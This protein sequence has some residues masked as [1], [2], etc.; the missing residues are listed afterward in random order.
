MQ[1]WI[2]A[3]SSGVRVSRC[4]NAADHQVLGEDPDRG[5]EV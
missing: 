5:D 2:V 4:R 1:Y 3:C